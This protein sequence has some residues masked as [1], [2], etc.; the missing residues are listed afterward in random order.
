VSLFRRGDHAGSP[1][2]APTSDDHDSPD[3]L[4]T[5]IVALNRFVNG[6]A[7]RLPVRAVV[8]A[9]QVT[10]VLNDVIDTSAVRPLDVYAVMSIKGIIDDY[11]P[12]TLQSFLAVDPALVGSAPAG[13][14]SPAQS[15][16]EQ[17]ETMESA[18]EAVLSAA[19]R[20][21]VDSLMTQGRFLSTKV[22]G[23]DLD[24]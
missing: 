13:G 18:A 12:T 4:R 14:L 1:A 16:I 15:L 3:A 11:L 7:G 9:R 10:D 17:L 24:L 20:Q 19:Q 2:A 21:D 5:R 23:S 8:G 22:T 6:S